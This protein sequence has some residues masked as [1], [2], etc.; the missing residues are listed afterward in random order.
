MASVYTNLKKGS[1][2]NEVSALQTALSK[3]GY[4]LQ[5]TGLYDD[6]T[7]AAV[8]QYQQDNNLTADGVAGDITLGTL[9]GT[10]NV[11]GYTPSQKLTEAQKNV[12]NI[13]AKKPTEYQ[14]AITPQLQAQFDAI[15]NRQP[16]AYD[17]G[18]D[19][20]FMQMG[21]MYTQQGRRAM[22]DAMGISA[23]MTGGYGNSYAQ[24]AGQAAYGQYLQQLYALAPEYQQA[25]FDR[26]QQEGNE[27][28]DRY[29]MLQAREENE[30][31]RYMDKLNQYYTELDRAQQTA[32]KLYEREYGEYQDNLNWQQIRDEFEWQQQ[33][34]KDQLAQNKEQFESNLAW[35]QQQHND[36]LAWDREQ[37]EKELAWQQQQHNDNLAWDREQYE[38]S[39]AWDK[40]QYQGQLD[41]ENREYAYNTVMMLLQGG[42]MPSAELLAMAGISE[43]DAAMLVAMYKPKSSGGGGNK[44]IIAPYADR[45]TSA[46][47]SGNGI[48]SQRD[49]ENTKEQLQPLY[50]EMKNMAFNQETGKVNPLLVKKQMQESDQA[51]A[52]YLENAIMTQLQSGRITEDEAVKLVDKYYPKS[53]L[54]K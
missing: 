22:Q 28:L 2:G 20:A 4:A 25:A 32:D 45:D 36:N 24:G 13:A 34:H 3:K 15:M 27:M 18:K 14:S 11:N 26:Y 9:Y 39:L 41:S 46:T 6:A 40:E 35:Q 42:Q 44:T 8:K 10:G 30:Y 37:Y 7:E 1:S 48:V 16:F 33:A 43:A 47:D 52:E 54:H 29:N 19:A 23:A 12:E 53:L 51:Y 38:N 17:L 49:Y 50:G 21:D 5:H 31:S